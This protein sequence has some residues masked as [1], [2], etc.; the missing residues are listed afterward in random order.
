MED[1]VDF[2]FTEG[3]GEREDGVTYRDP[4][5]GKG[6]GSAESNDGMKRLFSPLRRWEVDEQYSSVKAWQ[7]EERGLRSSGA[8]RQI[9]GKH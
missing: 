6:M 5:V 1:E 7:Q 9:R 2:K 3:N 4:A 8:A